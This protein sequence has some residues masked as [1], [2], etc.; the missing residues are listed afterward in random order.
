[1]HPFIAKIPKKHG[2]NGISFSNATVMQNAH[3]TKESGAEW[4]ERRKKQLERVHPAFH[5]RSA[6]HSFQIV[7]KVDLVAQTSKGLCTILD[8][9][10]TLKAVAVLNKLQIPSDSAATRQNPLELIIR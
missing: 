1:M 5:C 10:K 4:K 2:G 6:T 3:F 7:L 8:E 9:Y